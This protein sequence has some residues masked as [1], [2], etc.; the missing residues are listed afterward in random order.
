MRFYHIYSRGQ[1][2]GVIIQKTKLYSCFARLIMKLHILPCSEWHCD[3]AL[4]YPREHAGTLCNHISYSFDDVFSFVP[5]LRKEK[6]KL[7]KGENSR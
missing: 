3:A 4:L 7:R 5:D 2:L 1:S 6:R